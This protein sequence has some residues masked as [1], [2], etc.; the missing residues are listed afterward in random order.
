MSQA[1]PTNFTGKKK[2]TENFSWT[3][4]GPRANKTYRTPHTPATENLIRKENHFVLD[5]TAVSNIAN[6]YTIPT[7]RDYY[8]K[9]Y[10]YN[11][12]RDV[13]KFFSGAEGSG[14]WKYLAWRNQL[15]YGHS[16]EVVSG[17]AQY[18]HMSPVRGT[19]TFGCYRN[20]TPQLRKCSSS[21][22][23]LTEAP[24]P[25]HRRESVKHYL[26]NKKLNIS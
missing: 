4:K 20:N 26:S 2:V 19:R 9:A 11:H 3:L 13:D 16:T 8:S 7:A 10:T 1:R 14:G 5:C 15:G 22:G 23:D 21:F 18:M 6:K 24:T 17:H 12:V 25:L